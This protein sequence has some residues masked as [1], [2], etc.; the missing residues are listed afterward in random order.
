MD[1]Q[2]VS[3]LTSLVFL[4]TVFLILF[5][6]AKRTNKYNVAAALLTSVVVTAG[7]SVYFVM[8]WQADAGSD[9]SFFDVFGASVMV[10]M[11][12]VMAIGYH[13]LVS[14][15][16]GK[17]K[18]ERAFQ[19]VRDVLGDYRVLKIRENDSESAMK[20]RSGERLINEGTVAVNTG[21]DIVKRMYNEIEKNAELFNHT[22]L[23]G[24]RND[25]DLSKLNKETKM[26]RRRI[27]KALK[28]LLNAADELR[29]VHQRI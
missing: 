26:G 13:F 29:P 7:F 19:F 9:Q 17:S 27:R 1:F 5:V 16:G 2:I 10:W 24:W 22:H 18:E 11:F 20:I 6:L 23:M 14:K 25:I 28:G 8:E 3:L 21:H 4:G 12:A 15:R